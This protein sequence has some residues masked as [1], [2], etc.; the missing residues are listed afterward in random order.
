MPGALPGALPAAAAAAAPIPAIPPVA[1]GEQKGLAY[2]KEPVGCIVQEEEVCR[3]SCNMIGAPLQTLWR[4]PSPNSETSGSKDPTLDSE[5]TLWCGGFPISGRELAWTSF[6]CVPMG[7]LTELCSAAGASLSQRGDDYQPAS[8]SS[9][10][11]LLPAPKWGS[12]SRAK[13]CVI[14]PHSR[15]F[16]F[17][18]EALCG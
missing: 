7:Y 11:C 8:F 9:T 18:V 10:P 1:C 6:P 13:G 4:V 17:S 16:I 14:F 2:A 12:S 5:S 15:E 3:V